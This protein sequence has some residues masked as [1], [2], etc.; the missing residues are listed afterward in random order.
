MGTPKRVNPLGNAQRLLKRLWAIV[1]EYMETAGKCRNTHHQLIAEEAELP[2]CYRQKLG[3]FLLVH[4]YTYYKSK[5]LWKILKTLAVISLFL[6]F[7]TIPLLAILKLVRQSLERR[8][9]IP[10]PPAF[11]KYQPFSAKCP[12]CTAIVLRY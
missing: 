5:E 12:C 9:V 11:Q 7:Q 3:N 4:V 1:K 10:F 8:I 6:L 2:S